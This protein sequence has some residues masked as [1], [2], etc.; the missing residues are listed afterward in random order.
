MNIDPGRPDYR[1]V[2]TEKTRRRVAELFEAD[3]R[4]YGYE[5]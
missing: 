2:Y 4:E 5:F 3:L 1:E